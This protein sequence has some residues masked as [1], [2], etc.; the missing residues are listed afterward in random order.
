MPTP[1]PVVLRP[2]RSDEPELLESIHRGLSP[3]SRYLRFHTPAPRLTSTMR[4]V[5]LGVDEHRY[6]ALVA[7]AGSGQP[8]GLGQIIRARADPGSAEIAVAVADVWQRRGVGRDLVAGLTQQ[9]VTWGVHRVSARV[10]PENRAARRLFATAFPLHHA[11]RDADA[12][13][14]IGHV[15]AHDVT[16][17]MDDILADLAG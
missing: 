1:L 12:D 4:A 3:R 7:E 17:T 10:L 16:I 11:H 9:A 5:M 8:V 14:L 2:L 15:D 6:V 13:V